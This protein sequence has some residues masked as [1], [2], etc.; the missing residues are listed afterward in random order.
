MSVCLRQGGDWGGQQRLWR[1]ISVAV[2]ARA[3]RHQQMSVC[4]RQGQNGSVQVP[5]L[6]GKRS[7]TEET[8]EA[9]VPLRAKVDRTNHLRKEYL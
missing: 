4:L 9:Q 6:R 2:E 8:G 5:R 3:G 7:L 1:V